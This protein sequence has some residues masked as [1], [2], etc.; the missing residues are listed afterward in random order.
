[1]LIDASDFSPVRPP[2]HRAIAVTGSVLAGAVSKQQIAVLSSYSRSLTNFRF[3]LLRCLVEAGHSV[4]AVGP[5]QDD[6]VVRQL[7]AIGVEFVRS[8]MA[9]TGL[10]PL[11]DLATLWSYWRLFRSRQIDVVIPYTMKP[12]VYGGIAAR[13]AGVKRRYFLVTGLGHVYSDAA[14]KRWVGRR[15]KQLSVLLYRLALKGAGGVFAY[16]RADSAD[17]E[18]YRLISDH[19]ELTLVPGSGVDLDHYAFSSPPSGR[20]VFLLVARLL[21]DKGI[22]EFVEAARLVRQQFPEAEFRLL[23]QF[24]PSPAAISAETIDEWV[25]E[26]S[27]TYLGETNDVRP[28]LS[29]CSVFVLPS[30]YREGIP[31]SILEAMSTGRAIVTTDLPGCDETVIDGHNGYLV[32]ARNVKQMAEAM[33]R[34]LRSPSLIP[35]MG[36]RSRELAQAKF[37]VHAVNE[38]LLKRMSLV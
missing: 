18:S 15:I 1:M 5:E 14:G 3:E 27:V 9:R 20:P 25:K 32:E 12:I 31:R 10:N 21:K 6:D 38:L 13:L 36:L 16:N 8:P 28:H 2:P 11:T 37:D 30:Y 33:C 23:G 4:L 24:D 19:R 29:D 26:G 22:G 17:I 35:E 34:F 7:A